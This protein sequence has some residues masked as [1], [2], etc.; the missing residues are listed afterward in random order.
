MFRDHTIVLMNHFV[1]ITLSVIHVARLVSKV[2]FDFSFIWTQLNAN[3]SRIS[4]SQL[5]RVN[6]DFS[7][8][9]QNQSLKLFVLY[10]L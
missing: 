6:F 3:S 8:N 2:D 4:K 9:I 5:E 1:E 7:K 10:K